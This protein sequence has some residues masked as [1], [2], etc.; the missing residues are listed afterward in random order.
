MT[1]MNIV[2]LGKSA[3]IQNEKRC[4]SSIV[5]KRGGALLIFDAGEGMQKNFLQAKL[6]I[7]KKMKIFITHMN[8]DDCL[9]LMGFFST[10]SLLG[11][12]QK[13]AIYGEPGLNK[14]VHENIRI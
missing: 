12:T 8:I 11:R 4:L 13:I 10:M 3:A 14:C 1:N 9:G 2:F 6:G 7:N 5:V